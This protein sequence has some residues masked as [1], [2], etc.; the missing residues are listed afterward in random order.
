MQKEQ[1]HLIMALLWGLYGV[2]I[3]SLVVIYNY[4][5]IWAWLSVIVAVAGNSIHLITLDVGKK[6]IEITAQQDKTN[7]QKP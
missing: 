5:N 6:G 4:S 7:Q 1:V 3:G 2:I